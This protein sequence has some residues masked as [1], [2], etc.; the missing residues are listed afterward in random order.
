MSDI[1]LEEYEYYMKNRPHVV[2][3]G[4]GASCAVIPNGDKNGK[5]ISAMSGFIKKLGL[6]DIIE[7]VSINTKSDNLEDIYME[8]DERSNNE[9]DCFEVKNELETVIREYMSS[10]VLPDEPTVYDFLVMSLTSKDLIA[11]F[12]WDP[13][14]VQ[15]IARA[16]RY[17]NN[18]PQ[19]A[20]LHGNVAVGYCEDDN[21]M[22]NVGRLCKCGK[23]LSPMKLLFPI[24]KKDYT[25]DTAI[26]KSW[27]QLRNALEK[28][29]MVTIFGYSAPAS[30]AEAVDMLKQAWGA[31]D[32]R[33]LEEIE[34]IDIR[35][36]NEVI[37]SWSQFIHTHHYSYHTSFFDSTLA[38]CPRRSCE[39][40]FDRLMNCIWLD[41]SKG[42]KEGMSFSDIDE[43]T[44]RLIEE[45][46]INKG[47][48]KSLTNPYH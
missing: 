26:N 12:N 9:P 40:T 25:S 19:V 11:T 10:F 5:W 32:E 29:Y 16:Q 31:V 14:L 15:A 41:D 8:L 43:K 24:K 18:I 6:S 20:F 42:F 47:V 39:A 21:I 4:A 27:K 38:K 44:Y 13:F 45:E 28:A 17:T 48:R 3:L 37:K 2:I 34:L 36:E 33:K 23:P 46:C 1:S 7:K 30:D 35:D 22:G